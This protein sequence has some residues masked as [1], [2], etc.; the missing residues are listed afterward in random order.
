M[1]DELRKLDN[2][3]DQLKKALPTNMGGQQAENAYGNAYQ[4]AVQQ[5][6]KPQIKRKY[7]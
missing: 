5:G 2:A 4:I 3:S 6:L 7:R 1:A